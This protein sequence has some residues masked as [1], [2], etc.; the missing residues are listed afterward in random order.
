MATSTPSPARPRRRADAARQPDQRNTRLISARTRRPLAHRVHAAAAASTGAVRRRSARMRTRRNARS[1]SCQLARELVEDAPARRRFTA[2][3]RRRARGQSALWRHGERHLDRPDQ[4]V[5]IDRLDQAGDRAVRLGRRAQIPGLQPGRE[6]D[7]DVAVDPPDPLQQIDAASSP[8]SADR[9]GP[10][11]AGTC[12]T[13]PAPRNRPPPRPRRNPPATAPPRCSSRAS[14]SSSTTRTRVLVVMSPRRSNRSHTSFGPAL[15]MSKNGTKRRTWEAIPSLRGYAPVTSLA[16]GRYACRFRRRADMIDVRNLS[17]SYRVHKR[18][19]GVAAALRSVLQAPLRDRQGRRGSFLPDRGGRARRLPRPERRRQDD[20]AEGAVRAAAPDVG[21]RCASAAYV[22]HTRDPRFLQLI[23]LVMG[24]KQQLLWDLPPSDTYAMNRAIYDI[25]RAQAD[26]TVR[27][28]TELLEIGDLDRQADAPAVA[29]RAHEVRAGGGAAA[30]AARAVPRRADHRP[31]RLDAGEDARLHPRLQRALRRH[32][33][34]DQPLH[35]R[36]RR[37]VPARH[38]HRPRPPDLRRRPARA[39]APRAPRQ[40]RHHPP[41][42][43]GRRAPT[44]RGWG[45]SCPRTPRRRCC[46]CPRAQA[47]AV[48][49]DALATLPIVDLTIEDPPLEEVMR[50]LFHARGREPPTRASPR[51]GDTRAHG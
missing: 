22:P 29:R 18:A 21:R 10:R 11:P 46:R 9:S 45:R 1:P 48:V 3:A 7:R 2:V 43:A 36:R 24:Q 42:E 20:H 41:V 4:L 6:D 51:P 30:P 14:A 26:E 39:G 35:G 27:E 5:E 12:D 28:L 37:A 32:G 50:E 23:T 19:P 31:R 17:K 38:R 34:A 47:S 16:R 33:A 25:P 49:R 40:A 8:A 13:L 15:T 44:W